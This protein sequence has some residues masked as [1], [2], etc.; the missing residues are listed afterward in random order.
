M[1]GSHSLPRLGHHPEHEHPLDAAELG[2]E[3]PTGTMKA[4]L[5]FVT[6]TPTYG[7]VITLITYI[8]MQRHPPTVGGVR[9]VADHSPC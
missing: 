2:D 5:G 4:M 9:D 6:L 8:T 7:L 1:K 3:N